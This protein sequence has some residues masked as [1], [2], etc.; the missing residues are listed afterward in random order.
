MH[1]KLYF[2]LGYLAKF[3]YVRF[4]GDNDLEWSIAYSKEFNCN[5]E[6]DI[7]S[8]LKTLNF[9]VVEL[10]E[11]DDYDYFFKIKNGEDVFNLFVIELQV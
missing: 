5:T 4:V 11:Y 8:I 2:L 6:Q 10:G 1:D 7:T 9:E 3:G